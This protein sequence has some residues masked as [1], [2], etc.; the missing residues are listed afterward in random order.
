M[1]EFAQRCIEIARLPG[2]LAEPNPKVG[3]VVVHKGKVIGEGWHKRNG[4]A[5]AEV[6]AIVSVKDKSLLSASTLYVSLE[7]CNHHGKT[8]PCTGLILRHNIPH[9]IIGALDPNPQMSGNSVKMLREKGVKVEV[10]QDN[11]AFLELIDHF[12]YNQAKAKP[13]VTLKWAESADGFIGGFEQD[14]KPAPAKISPP[15]ITRWVHQLRH[16]H[17]AIMV[18]KN[19]VLADD[20]TLNTRHWPG[21]SPIRIFFDRKLEIPATAAIYGPGQVVVIN[22]IRNEV[23]GDTTYFVPVEEEAFEELDMLL[24]ELYGRL[25]IGSILVEGGANLLQQF[26]EQGQWNEIWVN[27]AELILGEGTT[28]PQHTIEFQKVKDAPGNLYH[29]KNPALRLV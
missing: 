17:Q 26:I 25:K 8:P 13:F 22:E 15:F 9:V 7:P 27:K 16:E 11:Q 24:I 28:A 19:T 23:V 14:G 18:G 2:G 29:R 1:D 10:I 3:A 4:T 12:S 20:P 21:Q 5:H 6:N